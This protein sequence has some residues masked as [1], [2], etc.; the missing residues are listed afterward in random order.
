VRYEVASG[1][2]TTLFEDSQAD[3]YFPRWSPDGRQ[4]AFIR[5]PLGA[6][7]GEIWVLPINQP[8]A[9]RQI[10]SDPSYDNFDPQWS[11][12]SQALLWSRVL[13]ASNRFSVWYQRLDASA[14]TLVAD[15]ALWPRWINE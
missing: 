12:D 7:H 14:P 5:R 4:I 3:I 9:G 6:E 2:T 13:P 8:S 1:Q 15:D 10:S 11:A